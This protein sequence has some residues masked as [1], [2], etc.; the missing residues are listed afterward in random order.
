MPFTSTLRHFI[1]R[2]HAKLGFVM[3]LLEPRKLRKK[4]LVPKFGNLIGFVTEQDFVQ[5]CTG[6]IRGKRITEMEN[7]F[8]YKMI[9]IARCPVAAEWSGVTFGARTK[10]LILSHSIRGGSLDISLICEKLS[11]RIKCYKIVS[12]HL[13]SSKHS[14]LLHTALNMW[15]KIQDLLAFFHIFPYV[16]SHNLMSTLKWTRMSSSASFSSSKA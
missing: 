8:Q 6:F 13:P 5:V 4:W 3:F 2:S 1:C 14:I 9:S 15:I 10:T 7:E 12:R 16:I 11:Q